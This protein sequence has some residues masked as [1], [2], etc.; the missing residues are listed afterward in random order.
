MAMRE[1]I[2][3]LRA[4]LFLLLAAAFLLSGLSVTAANLGQTLLDAARSDDSSA[5]T[6]L[7]RTGADV[8]AREQDG[9]TALSWAAMRNNIVVAEMLLKAG[10][11]PNLT[12]EL[13]VGPL[14][15][16]IENGSAAISALLLKVGA[17]ANATREDGATP[18]MNAARLGRLDLVKV[19][20]DHGAK[21]DA[22]TKKFDQTALMWAAGHPDVVRVLLERG[23]DARAVTTSWDVKYTIFRRLLSRSERRVFRGTQT[24]NTP[25]GKA[26]RMRCSSPFRS[27]MQT[28]RG[29]CSMRG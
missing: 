29:C 28:L 9:A 23:A 14:A 12:N 17:N 24:A 25:P 16:A 7:I 27:T 13:G 6:R 18:L 22:R 26:A 2:S 20:L 4:Y 3:S 1:L 8:N 21:C 15:L 10:A 19:L 11:N 5:V